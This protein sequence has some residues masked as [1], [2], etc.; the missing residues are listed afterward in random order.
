MVGSSRANASTAAPT[1]MHTR[2]LEPKGPRPR[3]RRR[4][5]RQA[6]QESQAA[7]AGRA[8]RRRPGRRRW[9]RPGRAAAAAAPNLP[10]TE[11]AVADAAAEGAGEE[12]EQL[13]Y[14]EWQ[15]VYVPPAAVDGKV[16]R[17]AHGHVELWTDA[18]LPAGTTRLRTPRWR[19]R[20]ASSAS[21]ARRRWW[22][23]D[24]GRPPGA[25]V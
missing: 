1:H 8:R 19:R 21:T 16:P 18:H 24:Q 22:A 13:L 11:L 7:A 25:Q 14:G 20:R 10:L 6:T 4:A 15:T 9:P 3:R 5:A 17:S 23:R 12:E 2:D